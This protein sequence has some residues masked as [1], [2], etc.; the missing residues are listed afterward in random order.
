MRHTS[1][2]TKISGTAIGVAAI[3]FVIAFS[4]I[5]WLARDQ[6]KSSAL[7]AAQ[8]MA[9][10]Y[11]NDVETG[12]MQTYSTVNG[13][14]RSL[15]AMMKGGQTDR[16]LAQEVAKG[17]LEQNTQLIGLSSYWEPNGFD[18]K[19]SEWAN[20]PAHDASGRFM[21]YWNRGA[22]QLAVEVVKGY[23]KEEG[24]EWYY[25]PR[26][27]GQF[28]VTEPY[29]F[30][31][32]GKDVLMASLMAPILKD[33]KFV[34]VSGA[35]YPLATLQDILSKV[36]PYGSGYAALI[37]AGGAYASHPQAAMM[38]KPAKDV[39]ADILAQ[40]K[41]GKP[42]QYID[43]A[44]MV[45]V[46]QPVRIGTSDSFWSLKVS[47]PLSAVMG[48]ANQIM[49]VS[50][51]LALASIAIL[52]VILLPLLRR[53]T[54]PIV[55]L[56]H[57]MRELAEGQ[58]DLTRQ[59]PVTSGDEIGQISS[60]FNAFMRKLRDLVSEVAS[61]S[62][63]LDS[64]AGGLAGSSREVAQ[65]SHQQS[66]ASTATA[67]AMEE[68]AV[69]IAHVAESAGEARSAVD[70][71]DRLTQTAH[72]QLGDTVHEIS[73][74][75]EGMQLVA[76]LVEKLDGRARDI[77]SIA[78]V[79]KEIAGQTNLL[80]LNAAIEAARAGEQGR[81]FAVVADEVRKLAERTT[82]AT[83]EISEKLTAIQQE[84][85]QAVGG[86]DRAVEQVDRG[87][88]LSQEAAAS[89]D[90]IQQASRRLVAQIGEI[91]HA[92]EE[93]KAA[94]N[95]IARSLEHISSMAQENDVSVQDSVGAVS[96]LQ[97]MAD[98]LQGL[99]GRFKV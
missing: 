40:I 58:G 45:H 52:A 85:A 62:S 24:N 43:D 46:F 56:T 16:M 13:L 27:T 60:A 88:S 66:D 69:S 29:A 94:G 25:V 89:I 31:V 7:L 11:A 50:V 83:I 10:S 35:D 71:A 47:F 14:S 59:L 9:R 28:Y 79:I 68:I 63:Q 8:D 36:K 18:G 4:L 26:K 97:G 37:S 87:V 3:T 92:A 51:V 42:A 44:G 55:S 65:R 17:M 32:G 81:G 38:N 49:W 98:Q 20:K 78:N 30:S 23:E 74:I 80:A 76:Q 22:G 77:S 6:A 90:G 96:N 12:F 33:G 82:Q 72:R 1:L 5:S 53:M 39:S 54:Q 75:N 93:Q 91:A 67:A 34:G 2:R 73:R 41:Q 86:V 57:T 21:T 64:A 99:V 84:T 15:E 19:D 61:Q 48:G 95:D 70:E